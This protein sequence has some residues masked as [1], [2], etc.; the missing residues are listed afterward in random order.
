MLRLSHH[1]LRLLSSSSLR[2]HSTVNGLPPTY[3]F[4]GAGAMAEAMIVPL[5]A[6][7]PSPSKP[8]IKINELNAKRARDIEAEFGVRA[9][10]RLEE[11]VEG[12]DMIIMAVKPQNVEAVFER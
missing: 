12:A 8:V 6:L 11:S 10:D 2:L 5:C 3:T 9:V 7:P 4:I 1:S